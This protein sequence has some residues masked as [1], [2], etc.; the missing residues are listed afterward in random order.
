MTN[1]KIPLGRIGPDK[2]EQ[3]KNC[4][5]KK[6]IKKIGKGALIAATGSAALF[7]LNAIKVTNVG[8]GEPLVVMLVPTLINM[9]KEW[10]KGHE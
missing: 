10:M 1:K 5:D 3:I 2:D 9:V 6:T 4:F 8:I 7:I